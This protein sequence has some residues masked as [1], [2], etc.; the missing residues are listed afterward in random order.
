MSLRLNELRKHYGATRAV[1]GVSLELGAR[2]TL[3]LLGPSGCG[4]STLLRLVAGLEP[5]DDGRIVLDDE[6][7][8]ALPPQRRRFGMVFQ[9]Y[10]LFP[11]LNVER[12]V[13][14]GLVELRWNVPDQ[15]A[16]VAELLDL[17][18]LSGLEQRRVQELSGGQQQRV[19]LARAL[20]PRPEVLLLDEPLSNLDQSLR[21]ALKEEL[22]SL[23]ARLPVRAI[24]VTH[25][26]SEA[27]AI[28]GRVAIM[29]EG[30]ITQVGTREEVL[31]RPRSAWSARFLGHRNLFEA[32]ALTAVPDVAPAD[33]HPVLLRADMVTLLPPDAPDGA[34]S[35]GAGSDVTGSGDDDGAAV[36]AATVRRARRDGLRWQLELDLPAWSLELAWEGFARELHGRP[37]EGDALRVR[38]PRAA[39]VRLEER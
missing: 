15:R 2:E 25:D 27:F 13:A 5:P 37:R 30:R 34:Y 16:R 17:V 11:H 28:A 38:V 1:D 35:D 19:A 10:A 23:L 7:I 39:W 32:A 31:E 14:F 21:E 24:Y 22:R 29:R 20:A 18:G 3:A 9:D 8:T 33:G 36:T 12:N 6:D 4:K 26:Q